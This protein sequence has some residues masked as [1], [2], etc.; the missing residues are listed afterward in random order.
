MVPVLLG[1]LVVAVVVMPA[2]VGQLFHQFGQVT[3]QAARQMRAGYMR[4]FD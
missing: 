4:L 3:T 2:E 1:L